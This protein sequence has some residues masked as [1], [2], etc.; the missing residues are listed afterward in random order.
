MLKPSGGFFKKMFS[1]DKMAQTAKKKPV[2]APPT[3]MTGAKSN[4]MASGRGPLNRAV[5]RK[6]AY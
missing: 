2:I 5:A 1:P 6:A 4:R 3:A